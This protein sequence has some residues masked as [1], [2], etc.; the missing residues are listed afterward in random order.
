MIAVACS[1]APCA[2][3]AEI[4]SHAAPYPSVGQIER[5][6][7]ALDALLAADAKIENLGQGFR[8]SEGPVWMPAQHQLVFSDVPANI[9]YRWR[10]G[11][12]IDVFLQ[13]SGF[14][15]ENYEGREA[16]SNGLT[17]DAQG[18]LVLCQHGNRCV[19]RLNDDGKT[20]T[21]IVDRFEGKRFSSPND[22]CFDRAGNLFFTD[23]PY[24]LPANTQP[25]I[26][27]NGVYRRA[28]DGTVTL[29]SRELERPNGIALAPDQRTLYVA[30]S[31]DPRPIIM[32]FALQADG[33]ADSGRIFFDAKSLQAPGRPGS[34]DGMR[35][36]ARGNLWATGPGGILIITPA[37]KHIGTILTGQPTANCTFGGDDGTTLY[38]TAN[39]LLLRVPTKTTAA[40]K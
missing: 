5:L 36:D 29:I 4:V 28:T 40:G 13:P 19:A 16:G 35:V 24:G 23:P 21:T 12:G 6:D 39:M 7:P 32:A 31:H 10:D 2:S 22:L 15:G 27:F 38:I 18:R 20:F 30:N 34:M 17:L 3:V 1:V 25:E 33:R 37:G 14:T 26:E 11:Q 8:W 9:A